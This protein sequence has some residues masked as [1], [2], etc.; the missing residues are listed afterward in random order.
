MFRHLIAAT[1][2]FSLVLGAPLT[3][4]QDGL[5]GALS[6]GARTSYAVPEFFSAI[7]VA[8]FDHDQ[9]PDGALLLETGLLNGNRVFRIELH[10]TANTNNAI[11]FSS[12][13]SGLLISTLDVNRDGAP[14][15]VI[16][17]AFTH[18]RIGLYLNDGSG[19]FH[20]VRTEDYPDPNPNTPNGRA[21][22][23]PVPPALCLPVS[24]GLELDRLHRILILRRDSSGPLRSWLRALLA[25][26]EPRAPASSR[27]PPSLLSI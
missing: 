16:E 2:L 26:S 3:R 1:V 18:Q 27:A 10:L 5:Q 20:R 21:L 17:K 25:P 13:E 8:D 19:A 9:K 22:E 15:I 4:A 23:I 14:D 12:N 7:A 11:S 6:G 24:R